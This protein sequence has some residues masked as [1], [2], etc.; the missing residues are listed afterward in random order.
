VS[1]IIPPYTRKAGA[2]E[3]APPRERSREL[4]PQAQLD[5]AT[6]IILP[7]RAAERRLIVRIGAGVA[8]VRMM[9]VG[10]G[11]DVDHQVP[12]LAV[13]RLADGDLVGGVH[14]VERR[15][16]AEEGRA[17]D[18]PAAGQVVQQRVLPTPERQIVDVVEV[19]EYKEKGGCLWA[20]AS[21]CGNRV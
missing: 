7:G 4:E 18:L 1:S 5:V 12:R 21:K 20:S 13:R 3:R 10:V 6:R 15:A 8:Q 17:G 11:V 9:M 16:S 19:E 2:R 14:H